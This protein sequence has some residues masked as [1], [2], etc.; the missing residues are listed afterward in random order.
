M[1][2]YIIAGHAA[3]AG[4]DNGAV[5]PFGREGVETVKLRNEII[6]NLRA[7]GKDVL[8]DAAY[9]GTGDLSLVQNWLI[10]V[11]KDG[12]MV[13]D[14]HFNAA[15]PAAT[16]TEVY[17]SKNATWRELIT[18]EALAITTEKV[19]SIPRRKGRLAHKTRPYVGVKVE[20]ESQHPRLWFSVL[21]CDAILWEV[22]F[23]TNKEE[24]EKYRDNFSNLAIEIS[25]TLIKNAETV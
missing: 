9:D 13:I 7:A 5:S 4:V 18:A 24:M 12:D 21:P 2:Y 3:A 22:C 11:V 14:I 25:K 19:L 8:D 6:R 15:T 20:D 16:G 10:K 23:I 17:I 1:R